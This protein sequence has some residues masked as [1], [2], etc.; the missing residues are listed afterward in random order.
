MIAVEDP[1]FVTVSCL[2]LKYL[3]FLLAKFI[4]NPQFQGTAEVVYVR[5]ADALAAMQKYSNVQLDGKLMKIELIGTNL[6][7]TPVGIPFNPIATL[8]YPRRG[9]FGVPFR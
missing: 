7:I 1:R 2:N 8:Q 3:C 4:C 9:G 5:K 6:P